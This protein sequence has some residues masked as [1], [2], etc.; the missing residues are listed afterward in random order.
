MQL[1]AKEL[2]VEI[3]GLG[4]KLLVQGA[5]SQRHELLEKFKR[6]VHSVLFGLDSFWMGVDVPGEALE[7]VIITRLPFAVPNHPL[8]EARLERIEQRGGNAFLEFSLPEAVLKFRQG[9]G[10]LLR[11]RTDKGMATILDSRILTRQY[12]R[13]FISSIPRCPVEVISADGETEYLSADS[14]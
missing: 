5:G 9:V 7:H 8:I 13:M 1:M 14:W 12:G 2:S 3:E 4:L 6:D 11:S 10:R